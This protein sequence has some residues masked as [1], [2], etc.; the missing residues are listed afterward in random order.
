MVTWFEKTEKLH[1]Q[2]LGPLQREGGGGRGGLEADGE[3]HHVPFRIILRELER[4]GRRIDD[5]DV[6]SARFVFERAPLRAGHAHH[7]AESCKDHAGVLRHT[8]AIIDAP[9]G[10]DA[11]RTA[12]TMD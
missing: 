1:A 8:Q 2:R 9:H 12:G 4:I 3:E 6:H 7:V 5:P 10:Q 11:D